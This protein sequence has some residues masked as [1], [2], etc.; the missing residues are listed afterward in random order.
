MVG[1]AG[2][3][4]YFYY[5]CR[6]NTPEY[7]NG[8]CHER[9]IS[10]LEADQLV[11]AKITEGLREPQLLAQQYA[12]WRE[13]QPQRLEE[14]SNRLTQV[15]VALDRLAKQR[16]RWLELYVDGEVDRKQL[17]EEQEKIRTRQHSL[18]QERKA[19]EAILY[20]AQNA[21]AR[22]KA[23]EEFCSTVSNRLDD[24]TFEEQQKILRLLNIQGRVS[25]DQIYLC[26]CLPTWEKQEEMFAYCPPEPDQLPQL[27][28]PGA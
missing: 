13:G 23:F 5:G 12:T 4:S 6:G 26:G 2:H 27:C 16:D 3:T 19:L 1:N 14:T 10:A 15:T 17:K 28:P 18:E 8:R 21:E 24:L 7:K 11:W 25:K 22:L 20:T 9:R